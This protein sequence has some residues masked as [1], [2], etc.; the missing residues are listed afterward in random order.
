LKTLKIVVIDDSPVI[1]EHLEQAF[2][3]VEGCE[4]QGLAKNGDEGLRMVRSLKPDVVILDVSLPL[5]NGIEVLRDIREGD[6]DTIVIMFTA[7]PS[8]ALREA[9]R[10]AGANFYLGK[11][12]LPELLDVCRILQRN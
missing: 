9:C 3:P 12:Q 5:R 4:I 11:A 6:P 7:D 8:L 1:R 2:A 10:D